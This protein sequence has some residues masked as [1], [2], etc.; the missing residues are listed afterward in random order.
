MPPSV[1][2]LALGTPVCTNGLR[3]KRLFPG[4]LG[5]TRSSAVPCR[6]EV[7]VPTPWPIAP[8]LCLEPGRPQ[9]VFHSSQTSLPQSSFATS[10]SHQEGW[11]N[12]SEPV[13]WSPLHGTFQGLQEERMWRRMKTGPQALRTSSFRPEPLGLLASERSPESIN[14]IL[15]TWS[16]KTDIVYFPGF[17]FMVLLDCGTLFTQPSPFR[18]LCWI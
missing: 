9:H 1:C 11:G 6:G 3:R 15:I 7:T 16:C 10:P 13:L 18:G 2:Q 12:N 4:R 8:H 17:A 5:L 14:S